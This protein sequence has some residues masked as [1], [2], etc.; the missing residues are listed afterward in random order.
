VAQTEEEYLKLLD[1]AF[2]EI[3]QK[4]KVVGNQVIPNLVIF[5]VGPNTVIKNFREYCD[6]IR[7]E[8]RLVMKY[9]LKELGAPGSVNESGQLVIQGKFS[10]SSINTLMDRFLKIY[11]RCS[12]CGS[13]DTVLKK[14]GK[15]WY[16][17]CL[18]CGAQTPVKPI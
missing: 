7:R 3:P 16:V 18:A 8:E 4:A 11:V 6:R 9:L 14:E 12:T 13:Y 15:V 2:E 17:S 10:S 1:R 5:N